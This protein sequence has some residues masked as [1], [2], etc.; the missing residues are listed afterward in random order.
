[1]SEESFDYI[2]V[3]A[4]S[5][6][7]VVAT[8]LVERGARVVLLEEGRND[9]DPFIH[10]PGAFIKVLATDRA[11]VYESTPQKHAGNRPLAVPVGRTV[12]GGSSVNAMVYMRGQPEDYDRWRALGNAGWGWNDVLPYFLKTENNERLAGPYH[13]NEG[14]LYVSDPRYRHPLSL[15]FVRAA[16]EIGTPYNDD[17]N[18]KT[19]LGVGFY[20]STTFDGR[21]GSVASTYLRR[22]RTSPKLTLRTS[23]RAVK[24]VF[25]QSK[26]SGVVYKDRSGEHVASAAHGVVLAAGAFSTPKILMLSGVGPGGHLRELGIAITQDLPGVGQNFQDHLDICVPGTSTSYTSLLGQD[27]GLNAV[28]HGLE[29]L[30]FKSGMLTSTVVECGAFFDSDGDGRADVQMNVLPLIDPNIVRTTEFGH[31]LT[32]NPSFLRPRSRG[33]VHLRSPNPDD[34]I[35]FDPHYLEAPE[36][37][38]ILINGVRIAQKILQAPVMRRL[39]IK[40]VL[41]GAGADDD[42]VAEHIRSYTKTVFHPT[43]TC[44]MGTDAM[45]VVDPQLKVRGLEGLWI[46][47]A[48]VMPELISGNTNAP[49]IMIGER[50][51]EFIGH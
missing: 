23:A 27:K 21:R 41:P 1:M 20:Q 34:P 9:N 49:T 25:N 2:V 28:R 33:T 18:A 8:R 35:V 4:G 15:A 29:W 39:G 26:A 38:Q 13:G 10:M 16:Q 19:Q 11:R 5:G 44:R 7:C 43:C 24:V 6:G 45:A 42:A 30:L 31:G 46:A 50:A 12:G 40:E 32:L 36:D 3:G 14:P 48:S 17:F 51:A 22:V 37:L 47:D